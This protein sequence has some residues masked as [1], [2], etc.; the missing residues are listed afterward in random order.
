MPEVIVTIKPDGSTEVEGKNFHGAGCTK[1]TEAIEAA[2][3]KTTA[4]ALKPEYYE[5]VQEDNSIKIT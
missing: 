4:K 3:G 1:A 5:T 2:L